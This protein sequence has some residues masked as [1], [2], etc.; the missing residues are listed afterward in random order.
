M[1]ARVNLKFGLVVCEL[2]LL[3]E[4]VQF[5]DALPQVQDHLVPAKRS[6]SAIVK[7]GAIKTSRQQEKNYNE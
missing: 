7:A 1:V 2:L 3:E 4:Q 5:L 6:F